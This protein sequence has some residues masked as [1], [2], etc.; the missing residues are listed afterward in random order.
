MNNPLLSNFL[1]PPFNQITNDC[2]I[3]AIIYTINNI[4][5]KINKILKKNKNNYN[6]KNFCQKILELEENLYRIFAPISHLNYV[7][8]NKK[9]RKNYEIIIKIITDYNIWFK[10]N[11]SLYKAYIYVQKNQNILNLN[12]LKIK[13]INDIIRDFNLSGILLNQ[14]KKKLY[15]QIIKNLLNL[16]N[17]FNNNIFDSTRKFQKYILDK[18]KLD[19]IPDYIIKFMHQNALL[20]NKKGYLITLDDPIYLSIITFCNNQNLRKKIYYKYSTRASSLDDDTLYKNELIIE[21]ELSLRLKLSNLLGYHSYSEQSLINKSAKK[22]NKV[23]SFLYKLLK[24]SKKQAIE[25]TLNLKKFIK[26]KYNVVHINAWDV[27]FFAEKYKFYLYGINNNII[28]EYFPINIV[29][30]GMFKIINNIYGLSFILEKVPVWDENVMF[31]NVFDCDN[32]MC[33]SIYFDLYFR[34]EKRSGAWMDICQS[35]ILKANGIL[36]HPVAFI[37]CNFT[38]SINNIFLLYHNDILTLFHEFGHALHH[39]TSCINI[40]NISGINGLPLDIVEFPSQFMEYWCWEYEPLKLISQHYQ[41]DKDMP[42]NLINKLITSKKYNSALLLMRQIELSLFDIRIHNEFSLKKNH[43]ISNLIKEIRKDI[44]TIST[45]P[46]WYKYT[47]TF[48][49]IFGG[50]YAAG[51]YSYLWSE[52]LAA[53]SFYHFKKNG[54]FNQTIGQN[55]L[56]NFL[57]LGSSIDPMIL[58]EKFSGRKLNCNMLL[59]QRGIQV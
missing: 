31:F 20:K 24:L 25:E 27:S 56:K 49:H 57:S 41:K 33:G 30:K 55:F 37:N 32:K 36:Q 58:F 1:L 18:K 51:Y 8:N 28:R 46:S 9:I 53:D 38:P 34:A 3:S 40:P 6:W 10:Q 23:L 12:Q 14:E 21:K 7:N 26:K 35:R 19:G 59:K 2:M 45:I 17:N 15:V 48:H 43:Q 13:S 54:L 42:I 16:Q 11:L 47:N 4:K 50:E 52:Q 29:I 22:V 5:K 39:I 44:V